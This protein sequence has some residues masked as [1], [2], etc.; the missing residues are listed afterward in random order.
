MQQREI[1]IRDISELAVI[2]TDH[3]ANITRHKKY[4]QQ[5]VQF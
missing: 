5:S 3:S 1:G 4:F 2:L